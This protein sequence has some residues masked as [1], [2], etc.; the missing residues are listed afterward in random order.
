MIEI[1]H[2]TNEQANDLADRIEVE[3]GQQL[4]A[5]W[6]WQAFEENGRSDLPMYGPFASSEL[7]LKSAK[8]FGG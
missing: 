6:Y 8:E 2:L 3:E 4:G 7:A 5:G 1:T